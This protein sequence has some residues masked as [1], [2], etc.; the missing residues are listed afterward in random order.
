MSD[1]ELFEN[2]DIKQRIQKFSPVFDSNNN[3]PHKANAVGTNNVT[4]SMPDIT[5]VKKPLIPPRPKASQHISS[6][7]VLP[8][9]AIKTTIPAVPPDLKVPQLNIDLGDQSN[10]KR[11]PVPSP[12]PKRVVNNTNTS[13]NGLMKSEQSTLGIPILCI[14]SDVSIEQK[15][16]QYD[17]K[18][19]SQQQQQTPPNLN[20]KVVNTKDKAIDSQGKQIL[21]QTNVECDNKE[22]GLGNGNKSTA[23]I[24]N[25]K[26]DNSGDVCK[27]KVLLKL[28]AGP[29]HQP[30]PSNPVH[31][32]LDNIFSLPTPSPVHV[33]V[34]NTL[35]VKTSTSIKQRSSNRNEYAYE[36]N[37][38]DPTRKHQIKSSESTNL[39][40]CR[41]H[42]LDGI[43]F[44]PSKFSLFL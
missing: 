23:N 26:S 33:K 36:N 8:S 22:N 1:S 34:E 14:D 40:D 15:V 20:A 12:K 21:E 43:V 16:F 2:L 6:N 32:K 24:S 13:N 18:S 44:G 29:P 25:D 9:N 42:T 3:V 17:D 30:L 27:E 4:K 28:S 37:D 35:S 41:R 11:S 19:I 39:T 31:K 5:L 10:K 38:I 7:F